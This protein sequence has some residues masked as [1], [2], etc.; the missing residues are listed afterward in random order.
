MFQQLKLKLL[1]TGLVA[2]PGAARRRV[3]GLRGLRRHAARQPQP[4]G[5]GFAH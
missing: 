2:T 4:A 1:A 3:A 5:G